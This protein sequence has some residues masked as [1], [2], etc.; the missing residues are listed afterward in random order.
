MFLKQRLPH[1]L[2]FILL[3][4]SVITLFTGQAMTIAAEDCSTFSCN[5]EKQTEQEYQ[6]CNNDKKSCLEDKISEVKTQKITLQSTV[7]L[8]NG[9]INLQELKITQINTEINKIEKEITQLTER[10][11][12]L[13]FSL[14]RLTTLL[15]ER[16]RAQHKTRVINPMILMIKSNSL[17]SFAT[18]YK[19]VSLASKQTAQAMQRAE[20]QKITYDEQKSLKEVK[21]NEVQAKQQILQQEQSQLTKQRQEQQF[22]L[23]QTK[24]DEVKYQAELARTMAELQAIQSIIAGKGQVSKIGDVKAGDKIANIIVGAS[25]CSN[26][27]HLHLEV[28]QNGINRDPASFL[29]SISANWNNSPDG[30]FSFNGDWDWPLNDPAKINQ[31]YGMTWYARVQRAYGGSPHTGIDIASKSKDYTVKAVK[32]GVAYQGSINCGGRPLKYVK[33]DH[34][35]SDIDTFYLHVNY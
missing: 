2:F 21:Q 26:G 14:D 35:D 19:Y 22:L 3:N 30:E 10:I 20:A 24:N 23:T 34:K 1:W 32:D 11:S 15:V 33:V 8:I 16:I 7:N 9:Q 29:K 6:Q 25:P 18:N 31:G 28:V 12:G 4:C 13:N 5:S 17:E 27:T